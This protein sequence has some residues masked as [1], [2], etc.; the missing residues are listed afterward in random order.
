MEQSLLNRIT[1]HPQILSGK[2]IIRGM[3]ISV[4]QILK[5]LAANVSV[6]ELLTEYPELERDDIHAALL[7]AATV[8][9]EERVYKI[10]A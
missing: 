9:S 6:E 5:S 7:Y 10:P 3:R 1:I 2:P 4:E 8:I